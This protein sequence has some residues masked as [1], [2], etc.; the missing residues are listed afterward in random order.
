MQRFRLAIN[1]NGRWDDL[2]Y[3][4]GELIGEWVENKLSYNELVE[5]TYRLTGID[6]NSDTEKE[7]PNEHDYP[8]SSDDTFIRVDQGAGVEDGIGGTKKCGG[9]RGVTFGGPSHDLFPAASSHWILP[10]VC[11]YSFG[12]TPVASTSQE[13]PLFMGQVVEDKHKLKIELGLYALHER[14]DIRVKRSTKYRFEAGCKDI[15]C[16]FTIV[17]VRKEHCTF[18][19]VKKFIKTHTCE[20]DMYMGQFQAASANVIGQ[21]YASKLSRGANICPKYIMR[22][23]REKHGVE[24]LYTKA[25]MTIQHARSTVYG[26][27]DESYQFL[28]GYFHMLINIT[29]SESKNFG[30][31]WN[32]L[33]SPKLFIII[34]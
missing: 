19:H 3:V 32:S 25:W 15:N 26:K 6:R 10:Y 17:A 21:L 30:E 16:Q 22:D 7:K 1:Y 20:E 9:A 28:P 4:D 11:Q 8:S 13:G 34:L 29:N 14:F 24:L 18:W 23:I 5:M 27:I 33:Y 31:E 12:T 2:D